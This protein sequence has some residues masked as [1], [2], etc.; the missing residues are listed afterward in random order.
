MLKIISVFTLLFSSVA[1]A[2]SEPASDT[3]W[4][5]DYVATTPDF[6]LPGIQFKSYSALLKDPAAFKKVIKVF[7]DRYGDGSIDAIAAL[8]ARGF[9]W[10]TALAY[11]MDLPLVMVRKAGKLPGDVIS[12][13]YELE[14]GK[15]TFELERNVL[16]PQQKVLI[17]D[18]LIATGGTVCA[19]GQLIESLGAQVA[20]VAC[21]IELVALNGQDRIPYPI[22]SLIQIP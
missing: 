8:D 20:E 5:Q 22:F 11:E 9:I 7:A 13:S 2:Y 19:A 18:D 12:V 21:F 1:V 10:G 4:M 15:S 14:Y 3:E 6:P 16:Q 17:I